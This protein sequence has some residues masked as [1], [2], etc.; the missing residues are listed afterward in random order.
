MTGR[1][2]GSHLE[3]VQCMTLYPKGVCVCVYVCV[4]DILCVVHEVR[5][6]SPVRMTS[7]LVL[8]SEG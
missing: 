3:S 5:E 1:G 7:E 4:C 8:N 6:C 2:S